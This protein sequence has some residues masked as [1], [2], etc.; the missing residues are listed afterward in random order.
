MTIS[1]L[2]EKYSVKELSAIPG[3][4][5]LRKE[6]FPPLFDNLFENKVIYHERVTFVAK[7]EDIKFLSEG[8]QATVVPYLHIKKN[9]HSDKIYLRRPQRESWEI[10]AKWDHFALD[11]NVLHPYGGAWLMWCEPELVKQV[12]KLV[13]EEKYQ[14]A[15]DLTLYK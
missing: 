5:E 8:F 1:E 7:L 10:F 2:H 9:S 6:I 12:E 14:E 13:L 15:L 3:D 4:G 11:E